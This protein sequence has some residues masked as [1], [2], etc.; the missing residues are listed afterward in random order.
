MRSKLKRLVGRDILIEP[1]SG[2]FT[3]NR[4]ES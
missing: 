1:E 4:R 3:M 2:L